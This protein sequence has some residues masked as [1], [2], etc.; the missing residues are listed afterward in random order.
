M[1]LSFRNGTA[2]KATTLK[3]HA[4]VSCIFSTMFA[5]YSSRLSSESRHEWSLVRE[6]CVQPLTRQYGNVDWFQGGQ[7]CLRMRKLEHLPWWSV[8][9]AEVS[10]ARLVVAYAGIL[11]A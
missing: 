3:D 10:V 2:E 4:H 8:V 7:T 9:F 1:R 5:L 11:L 6:T